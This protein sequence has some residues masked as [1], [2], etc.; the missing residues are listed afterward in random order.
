MLRTRARGGTPC[1]L[2]SML[3]VA[4][5]ALL[6]SLQ[7]QEVAPPTPD[8]Q[9]AVAFC[10]R[11][12]NGWLAHADART[13]LLPRTLTG[14]AYWNAKDC[15]ADNFPFLALTAHFTGLPHLRRAADHIFA[16]EQKLTRH[17]SGLPDDF[18][19]ATQAL[20]ARMAK[21]EELVFGAAEYCKDGLLPLYEWTGDARYLRRMTELLTAIAAQASVPSPAGPLPSHNLEVN[22]DLL[23]A[24]SRAW[25]VTGNDTFRDVAFRLAE[26]YLVHAPLLA[27]PSLSL[28]DHGCE[29]IGGLSEAYALARHHEPTRADA[30]RGPLYALLDCIATHGVRDDG[31]MHTAIDPR[32]GNVTNKGASDGWGYVFDAFLTVAEVDGETRFRDVVARSLD[33]VVNVD[34]AKTPG[35]GGADGCADTLEGALNILARIPHPAASAWVDREIEI[36]FRAQRP[37]GVLEAWYGDGNSART[38]WMWALRKTQG[39][40]VQPWRDDVGLT[41]VRAD[42]GSLQ[43]TL[44]ADFA[45]QG[46]VRCDRPRHRDV[47]RMPGDYARINQWPEWFAPARH[48]AFAFT[49]EGGEARTLSGADLW[50]MPMALK[51]KETKRF[52]LVPAPAAKPALRTLAYAAR[53]DSPP[54]DWQRQVRTKLTALLGVDDLL[55]AQIPLAPQVLSESKR[56]GYLDREVEFQS[57][58]TRRMRAR[59]TIPTEGTGPF[60]AVVCIHGHGGSRAV[61]HDDKSIYRG[62]AAELAAKGYVTIACD[63]GQH[64][65]F[66]RDRTLMGERFFDLKRCVDFLIESGRVD[67]ARIG[68]AGLSLGGEMAMWLGALD[69]RIAATVSCGFLTT[70]DQMEQG[71][72]RC[73]DFPGLRA[74]VDY[75]DIYALMAPHPLQCQNGLGEGPGDF[76]V[77]LARRAMTQVRATYRDLGAADAAAVHVHPEGHVVDLPALLRFFAEHLHP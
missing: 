72:C 20:R 26:H 42:D 10:A 37:D 38:M 21:P 22:G 35:L 30:W 8:A 63:V 2:F 67:S 68:C 17:A 19:F 73:W 4:S 27:L 6:L 5:V 64:A 62:F 58:P 33:R 40:T 48:D 32:S 53:G 18:M 28:R 61:V 39:I 77:P 15:A 69:S 14:D 56:T 23:Q 74:L 16:Q 43:V 29:V 41:V 55:G 31:L 51:A 3:I 11:Y 1:Y 44:R 7:A 34:V 36:L 45:W 47:M 9:R 59:V 25:W 66:E 50:A 46:T 52:T 60:P 12:A 49:P 70:M 75:A 76:C 71:H 57:T 54:A 24:M 65:V 13:G